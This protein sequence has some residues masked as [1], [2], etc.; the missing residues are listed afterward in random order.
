[1]EFE[2]LKDLMKEQN[3]RYGYYKTSMFEKYQERRLNRL[4]KFTDI[5]KKV[6]Q[7]LQEWGLPFTLCE[8]IHSHKQS[9]R[10][11]TDIFIPYGN[12]IM[13]QVDTSDKVDV[14]KAQKLFDC[15]KANFYPFFIRDNESE[16][17]VMMKLQDV[18]R[19]A[20]ALPQRG[21]RNV[22]FVDLT[23]KK[24]RRPRIKA[25]KIEPRKKITK[26]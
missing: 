6:I 3:E 13:R 18:L 10:V 14:E 1:M 5:T 17:F 19:K 15:T 12:I 8:L 9:Q 23:K 22:K 24:K 26:Y 7:T 11:T 21:F 16:D 2:Q 25:V 20:D 4:K